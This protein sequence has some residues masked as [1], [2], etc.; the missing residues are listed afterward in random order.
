[1]GSTTPP[2]DPGR[3]GYIFSNWTGGT[4]IDVTSDQI[5]RAVFTPIG[6]DDDDD[7]NEEITP[8]GI[9]WRVERYRTWGT[10]STKPANP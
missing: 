5:I 7:D 2:A 8:L 6:D 9:R 1:M 4:W 3:T 10:A